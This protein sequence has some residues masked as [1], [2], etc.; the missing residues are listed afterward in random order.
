MNRNICEPYGNLSRFIGSGVCGGIER[1]QN[2]LTISKLLA[3]QSTRLCV[4]A[5]ARLF[6]A[7]IEYVIFT[8]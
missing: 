7:H 8:L 1:S 5:T 2:T 4:C 3:G 6:Y